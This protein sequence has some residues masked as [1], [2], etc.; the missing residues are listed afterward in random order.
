MTAPYLTEEELAA[1]EFNETAPP[2]T[3]LP[4]AA[5]PEVGAAAPPAAL[6]AP[7][8]QAPGATGATAAYPTVPP[9]P[10]PPPDVDALTG[11]VARYSSDWMN[12]PNPYLSPLVTATRESS[13]ARIGES[14]R[15]AARALDE[16]TSSRGLLGSSV[17]GELQVRN[18]D[19]A[20]RARLEDERQLQEMLA[21]YETLGRQAAGTMGLD[22]V[23]ALERQREFDTTAGFTEQELDLRA[24][25]V[26]NEGRA[27][28][29]QEARDIASR[30]LETA[31]LEQS[32]QQFAANLAQRQTEFASTIGLSR[33]QF[34]AQTAQFQ[35]QFGEQ[36]ASRL[37]QNE[38]FVRALESD[39]ARNA[40][41]V[42]LQSRALDLQEAGMT[43]ED[44][45]RQAT[46]DQERT[47]TT[48]AQD[49]QEQGLAQEDAYRYA[50]L[51]QDGDFKTEQ[52]RLE[53]MGLNMEDSYR[54][55][56]QAIKMRA[57]DITQQEVDQAAERI[58]QGDRSLDLQE[59]RDLAQLDLAR[60]EMDFR[61]ELQVN[62]IAQRESEFARN[63]GLNERE[64]VEGQ[65]QFSEQMAEQIS[66]RFQQ[67]AQFNITIQQEDARMAIER[68]LRQQALMLQER[69]LEAD[70]AF[71]EVQ[72]RFEYGYTDPETGE[73]VPGYRDRVLLLEREGMEQADAYRYAALAQ[74]ARFTE[75][76]QR[77][78]ELG[79]TMQEAYREADLRLRRDAM[80]QQQDQFSE[81]LDFRISQAETD[82]EKFDA[83]YE[84]WQEYY[85]KSTTGGDPQGDVTV[86]VIG[87]TT[88]DGT[89]GGG[90]ISDYPNVP[91]DD[92]GAWHWDEDLGTWVSD[93]GQQYED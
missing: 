56:E 89:A 31:K 19:A 57:L 88:G 30:E 40:L 83:M 91:P 93:S 80:L 27:L 53:E 77:L 12:Q 84:L 8:A 39:E 9:P 42:G 23:S 13:E 65:R 17:E 43:M 78:Q 14:E 22:T 41:S 11:Q 63:Y 37:Q 7:P 86:N 29:L 87:G 58:R 45:W 75:E 36:V 34:E 6:G 33:E 44:A 73:E 92:G 74:D 70:I 90:G 59:A 21:N 4:G 49:L 10:P 61:L 76:A 55:A 69:G 81:E 64:F 18:I 28:D 71:Q 26:M 20:R 35:Q 82:K 85:G 3:G 25:Q 24:Q 48:R 79:L 2:V 72:Q 46:L 50:A 60:E 15:E 54:E 5:V 16:W 52:L 38:Q 66:A 62:E 67:D 47:L 32:G 68:G 1:K 51:E